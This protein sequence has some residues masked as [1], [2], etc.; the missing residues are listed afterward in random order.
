M[1]I[2]YCLG[3]YFSINQHTGRCTDYCSFPALNSFYF[4]NLFADD[5]VSHAYSAPDCVPLPMFHLLRHHR[6]CRYDLLL[7]ALCDRSDK[8]LL[9]AQTSALFCYPLCPFSAIVS[10]IKNDLTF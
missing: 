6:V 3:R 2:T 1:E 10:R 8:R 7:R 4:D 9:G 5:L